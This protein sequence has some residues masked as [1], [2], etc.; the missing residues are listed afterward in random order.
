MSDH[1]GARNGG[2]AGGS[3][4]RAVSAT[5]NYVL[6]LGITSL[7]I[8]GL[9]IAG[10]GYM[11][12]QRTIAVGDSLEVQNEKLADSIGD[13]D[14]LAAAME[15]ESGEAAIRVDLPSR[16]ID[17]SYRIAVTNQT[18]ADD[19]RHTYRLESSSGDVVRSTTIRTLLPIEE[20]SIRGGSIVV[21]YDTVG[22]DPTLV[23]ESS[24]RLD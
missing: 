14:R 5:V 18:A 10:S 13:V 8:S 4:N 21:R 17:R 20:T 3:D 22:G 2:A 1:D 9:L 6:A 15:N 24:N 16:V 11:E 19:R 7:L 23:L 12:S